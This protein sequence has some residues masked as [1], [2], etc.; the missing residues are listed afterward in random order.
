VKGVEE[1]TKTKEFN[2]KIGR[3]DGNIKIDIKIW[4]QGCVN[5]QVLATL[6]I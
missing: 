2:R 6:P 5:E 4:I 1:A 3:W